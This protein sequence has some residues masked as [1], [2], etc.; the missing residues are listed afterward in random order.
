MSEDYI[1]WLRDNEAD[2]FFNTSSSF[3][4]DLMAVGWKCWEGYTQPF[5]EIWGECQG[6]YYPEESLKRFACRVYK[7]RVLSKLKENPILKELE[8]S[9]RETCD[10]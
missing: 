4:T 8:V 10:R 1:A 3:K 2:L 6:K 9:W 5:S 7:A